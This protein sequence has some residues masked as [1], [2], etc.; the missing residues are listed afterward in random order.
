M[1]THSR[2]GQLIGFYWT[3]INVITAR[4]INITHKHTHISLSLSSLFL[5]IILF[6][7]RTPSGINYDLSSC[8]RLVCVLY[9][10]PTGVDSSRRYPFLSAWDNFTLFFQVCPRHYDI[11]TYHFNNSSC[12]RHIIILYTY[13]RRIHRWRR[14][15]PMAT[16]GTYRY[17]HLIT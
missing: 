10:Q 1:T 2:A 9:G 17:I 14:Y 4:Y 16:P 7:C 6:L 15:L 3:T 11:T 12:T 5:V 13:L 8:A